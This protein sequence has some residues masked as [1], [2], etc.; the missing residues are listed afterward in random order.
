MLQVVAAGLGLRIDFGN[1]YVRKSGLAT[2]PGAATVLQPK[3]QE[4]SVELLQ[5]LQERLGASSSV[6]DAVGMAV[7]RGHGRLLAWLLQGA[8][9]L[10]WCDLHG[11]RGVEGTEQEQEQE[12]EA[13]RAGGRAAGRREACHGGGC[14]GGGPA[15]G[16]GHGGVAAAAA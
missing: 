13:G 6:K 16:C 2:W 4:G 3:A 11:A 8:E 7:A 5:L 1:T 15:G 9:G 12:E 10:R 14:G